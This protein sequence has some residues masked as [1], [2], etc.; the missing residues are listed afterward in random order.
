MSSYLVTE[1]SWSNHKSRVERIKWA[2]IAAPVNGTV[3]D[4]ELQVAAVD[5][6]LA[7]LARGDDVYAKRYV[8]DPQATPTRLR[9]V[10]DRHGKEVLE[11]AEPSHPLTDLPEF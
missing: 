10:V 5:A 1:V 4:G 6:A 7:A 8:D 11:S 9:R 3:F 2:P